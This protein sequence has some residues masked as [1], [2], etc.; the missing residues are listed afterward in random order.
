M[1]QRC[2]CRCCA[3]VPTDAVGHVDICRARGLPLDRRRATSPDE[4]HPDPMHLHVRV[5]RREH[6]ELLP[7][8]SPE[9]AAMPIRESPGHDY[10]F[11]LVP[12]DRHVVANVVRDLVVEAGYLNFKGACQSAQHLD[13]E[14]LSMLHRVWSE[15]MRRSTSRK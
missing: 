11:R 15:L 2:P 4:R 6:L 5:R 7:L 9:L 10:R 3:D 8:L 1:V 12:V 14:F 13:D